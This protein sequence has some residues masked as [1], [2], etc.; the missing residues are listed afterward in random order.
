[1]DSSELIHLMSINMSGF[2]ADQ[3]T[4]TVNGI[5]YDYIASRYDGYGIHAFVYIDKIGTLKIMQWQDYSSDTNPVRHFDLDP[6]L[7]T[8]ES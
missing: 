5:T 3:G 8:D 6:I 2:T 4:A 1:M 7:V